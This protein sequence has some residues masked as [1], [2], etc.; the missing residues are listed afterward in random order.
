[1]KGYRLFSELRRA[2]RNHHWERSASGIVFPASKLVA[3]GLFV[4]DV[5]GRDVREDPNLVVNEGL[6]AM[7]DIM[8]HASTQIT[9]WYVSLSSGNVSPAATWTAANYVANATEFTTYTETVRQTYVEAAASSQSTTN[10]ASK[11]AFTIDTGGGSVWGAAIQSVSTKSG[12][13]GTLFC[14]AKFSAVRTL[15]AT[16][17]LSIAYTVSLTSS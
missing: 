4:T 16:D 7:L 10:S 12:T 2:L 11:A 14:A 3:S 15:V 5:N 9:T 8:L 1:M 6:N 17:V 13:T